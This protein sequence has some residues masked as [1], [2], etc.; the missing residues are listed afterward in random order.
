MKK[1]V[2]SIPD[3]YGILIANSTKSDIEQVT[4]QVRMLGYGVFDSGMNAEQIEVVSQAFDRTRARYLNE[5]GE[6][7]LVKKNEQHTIRAM[8]IHGEPIF[9]QLAKNAKLLEIVSSLIQ[10]KFYLNQQNGVINPPHEEYNQG[11]WHRDLPYQ[12]FVSST[13]LAINALFC[14]DDFT[15]N[16]GSTL[17]LPSTHKN[18][19]FPSASFVRANSLQITAKAGSFIVLDCMLYHKG[20]MN[21]TSHCRRAVNHLYTIPFIKQQV[22]LIRQMKLRDLTAEEMQ[23]FGFDYLEYASISEFLSRH[24][25]D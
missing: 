2:K 13:P 18:E 7:R 20:G 21:L 14:V 11:K 3:A 10:G 4:E 19:A 8:L 9:I 23:L 25:H 5:F 22:S 16:N 1:N 6:E 15:I 12:H 17:V 24:D